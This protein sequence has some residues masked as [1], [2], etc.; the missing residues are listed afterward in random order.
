MREERWRG[1]AAGSW[2]PVDGGEWCGGGKKAVAFIVN[3]RID[4]YC[5]KTSK[6][7]WTGR[8]LVAGVVVAGLRY[9]PGIS[10]LT[11]CR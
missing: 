2:V 1:D 9:A 10:A 5:V 11:D 8:A 3:M 7:N 4:S 6:L